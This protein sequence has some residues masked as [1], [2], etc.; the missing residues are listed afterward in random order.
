MPVGNSEVRIP[1]RS[2]TGHV[3]DSV[4]E[5]QIQLFLNRQ[6]R[7][8]IFQKRNLKH[9]WGRDGPRRWLQVNQVGVFS[10]ANEVILDQKLVE[11]LQRQI[12]IRLIEGD[13]IED[14]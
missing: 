1:E 5:E 10:K 11:L 13:H 14:L 12:V 3:S 8:W 4:Q 6:S 9:N 7:V 2:P